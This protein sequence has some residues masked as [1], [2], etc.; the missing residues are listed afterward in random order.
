MSE[1]H[2]ILERRRAGITPVRRTAGPT[3]SATV[4]AAL[5]VASPVIATRCDLGKVEVSSSAGLFVID[6]GDFELLEIIEDVDSNIVASSDNQSIHDAMAF[7]QLVDKVLPID[8][9]MDAL[10]E[11]ALRKD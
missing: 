9:N 5:G 6:D 8:D 1:L 3:V 4:A 11:R 7:A 2:N 10:V